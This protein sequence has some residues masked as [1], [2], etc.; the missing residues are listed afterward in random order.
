MTASD[1][2]YDIIHLPRRFN[3]AGDKSIHTLLT[4]T[5]YA[6]IRDQITIDAIRNSLS[7][8]PECVSDWMR[9]SEDKRTAGG[10]YFKEVCSGGFVVGSLAQGDRRGASQQ[11]YGDKIAA[12]AVFVKQEI[13]SII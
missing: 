1:I 10:C 5:G 7:K 6:D 4:E 3:E 8:Y 12:C 9:Y 2:L 13:D 11:S